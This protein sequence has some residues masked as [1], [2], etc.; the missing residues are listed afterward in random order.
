MNL[1]KLRIAYL[2]TRPFYFVLILLLAICTLTPAGAEEPV[3][4][5]FLVST[6]TLG[7][8]GG[9]LSATEVIAQMQAGDWCTAAESP[10]AKQWNQRP[11]S[12]PSNVWVS[13]V[14]TGFGEQ[15]NAFVFMFDGPGGSAR[16]LAHVAYG[17]S[18]TPAVPKVWITPVSQ[19]T[20]AFRIE[21]LRNVTPVSPPPLT[22]LKITEWKNTTEGT[23]E[24]D[25]QPS[26]SALD[27]I[28]TIKTVAT[29]NINDAL[30]ALNAMLCAAVCENG[31]APV[32]SGT[33][34]QIGME[35]QFGFK[36]ASLR[37]TR[38][39][40]TRTTVNHKND[41]P[42]E[43]Y[44]GA[45]SRMVFAM[46]NDKNIHDFAWFERSS[47]QLHAGSAQRL[48]VTL[49]GT[50]V[51][52]DPN[53]GKQIWPAAKVKPLE[54]GVRIPYETQIDGKGVRQLYRCSNGITAIDQVTGK[55][56]Q[57]ANDTPSV[58]GGFAVGQNATTVVA[59]E[60]TIVASRN[61][62][63]LWKKKEMSALSAGPALQGDN[64]FAGTADGQLVCLS[65]AD[66]TERWRKK[67]TGE[68]RGAIACSAEQVLA[69]SKNEDTLFAMSLAQG[70][71]IWKQSVGD[72]L[73]KAPIMV[74][75][76]WLVVGKNNRI[77]T[78]N[79]A[80]GKIVSDVRWPTWLVDVL[81]VTEDASAF[82][83]CTDFRNRL[84]ILDMPTLKPLRELHLPA[85]LTGHLL[86]APQFP[87]K[88][89]AAST[90]KDLAESLLGELKPVILVN[91]AEGFFYIVREK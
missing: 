16:L 48:L 67:G 59:K 36:M 5:H 27:S 34:L 39:T 29:I 30:P 69:F 46:D 19:I 42:E 68:W 52:Y 6:F 41:I 28:A 58:P 70:D 74:G 17:M 11:E 84:S 31:G 3:K 24:D 66:G 20:S 14:L 57:L 73:L 22:C 50:A 79:P 23:P 60:D 72:V 38:K 64:V 87:V 75:G 2:Q 13:V 9:T 21:Y 44:Y 91:D 51:S 56:T 47:V 76:K 26:G 81:P 40:G 55:E 53:T 8:T 86:Y 82:V 62:V 85:R 25:F 37:L 18:W 71:I 65:L 83:V 7:L 35:V 1:Q 43:R 63:V 15:A 89:G 88:W 4:P 32:W 54:A 10:G 90:D 45:L 77:L 12:V 49:E 61:G 78:L 33:D 80:D